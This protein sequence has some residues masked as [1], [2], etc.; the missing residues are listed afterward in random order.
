MK[1]QI[2][3]YLEEIAEILDSLIG[4]K[5]IYSQAGGGNGSNLLQEYQ[6]GDCIW[7]WCSYWEISQGD[8]LIANADDDITALVGTVAV[9][10]KM[11][12]EKRLE[13]Y[14]LGEDLTLGL[15]F[16]DDICYFI[17]PEKEEDEDASNWEIT[18]KHLNVVYEVQH[19]LEIIKSPYYSSDPKAASEPPTASERREELLD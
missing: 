9:G 3:T 7:S 15:K 2:R 17:Y 16:E 18:S 4:Q 14:Y 10:A 12:E 5:A 19:D 13:G 8:K 1:S 11:M 6:N